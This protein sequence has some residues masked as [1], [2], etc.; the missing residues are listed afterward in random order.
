MN[1][2]ERTRLVRIAAKRPAIDLEVLFDF[3]AAT[4]SARSRQVVKA[5]G[6]ALKSQDLAGGTFMIAGHTDAKGKPSY[7]QGLSERRAQA[8]KQA[9]VDEFQ[10]P[11][12]K[13]VVA[14]YGAER[15]KTPDEPYAD[16]NRRVEVINMTPAVAA[17]SP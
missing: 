16:G 14:G 7:N 13:L 15:L 12:D 2:T 11:A 5:L 3:N 1:E 8:V 6:E 17:S 9:L 4:I 10:I